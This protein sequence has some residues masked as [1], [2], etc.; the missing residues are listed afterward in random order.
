MRQKWSASIKD[1]METKLP[2]PSINASETC[3]NTAGDNSPPPSNPLSAL[4]RAEPPNPPDA[5]AEAGI[6]RRI[7]IRKHHT[8][9]TLTDH[10]AAKRRNQSKPRRICIFQYQR[11]GEERRLRVELL[12][13]EGSLERRLVFGASNGLGG[14][15]GV[16]GIRKRRR[17]RQGSR[18]GES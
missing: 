17:Q 16:A 14:L 2:K 4:L 18:R 10:D 13:L 8:A 7:G 12:Q 9:G 6:N 5:S 15:I 11:K 3:G 1:L